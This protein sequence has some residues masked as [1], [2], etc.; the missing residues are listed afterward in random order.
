MPSF[1]VIRSSVAAESVRRSVTY[2]L[3]EIAMTKPAKKLPI[4]L[5]LSFEKAVEGLL[6]IQPSAKKKA[7]KKPAQKRKNKS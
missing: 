3:S 4:K 6:A 7:V 2:K 5:P 1:I